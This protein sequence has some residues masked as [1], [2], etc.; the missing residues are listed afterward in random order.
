MS[1]DKTFE[2]LK[3]FKGLPTYQFERRIDAFMLPYLETAFNN[4]FQKNDFKLVYPEF[5]L[6]PKRKE[7]YELDK[8]AQRSI[9]ADYIMWS[10]EMD[11]TIFLVEFKTDENSIDPNQ[12]DS[13]ILNCKE[14]WPQ[15]FTDYFNKTLHAAEN[16][17][18]WR[19][20]C[21]GLDF[22]YKQAKEL[23]GVSEA[24]D[25]QRFYSKPRGNGVT[26]YLKRIKLNFS[27]NYNLKLI[28]LA[29]E[30]CI[31]KI[32]SDSPFAKEYYHSCISLSEIAEYVENPLGLILKDIDRI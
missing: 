10:K 21:Y 24:F 14:G 15:L 17:G 20:F 26:N 16:K 25:L 9:Y 5:P 30:R 31:K 22:F 4:I 7:A 28:Y 27:D 19:K 29:P 1:I 18:P 3:L 6:W 8:S 32:K 11:N 12:F 13:Y 23:T 2:Y